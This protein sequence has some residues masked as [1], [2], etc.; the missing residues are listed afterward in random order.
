MTRLFIRNEA[1]GEVREIPD[2][3]HPPVSWPDDWYYWCM[4]NGNC[5]GNREGF[6]E[7]AGGTP[8]SP[9]PEYDDDVAFC[10]YCDH[11]ALGGPRNVRRPRR[12]GRDSGTGLHRRSP[13]RL[14]TRFL[15]DLR[16]LGLYL[17]L[18]LAF[19]RCP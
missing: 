19:W 7:D 14:M 8:A 12:G 15:R 2:S 11:R 10:E 18:A 3:V 6:F 13:L 4:G 5:D 9:L 1:T 16:F 17:C